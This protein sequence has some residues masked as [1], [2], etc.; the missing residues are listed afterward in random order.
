M[1]ATV[2][3]QAEE[4]PWTWEQCAQGWEADP[5]GGE[6]DYWLEP[7]HI[8]GELPEGL[9]GTLLRNGPGSIRVHGQA[10]EHPIDGDG[11]VAGLTFTGDGR[12]HYRARFV[13]SKHRRVETEAQQMRYRGQMGSLPPHFSRLKA[14]VN[15]IGT[16]AFGRRKNPFPF[17]NPSNTNVFYWAGKLLA[18]Y[19]THMPHSLHPTTFETLGVERFDGA[20]KRVKTFAAHFRVDPKTGHL[21]TLSA[22]PK[23]GKRPAVLLFSEFDQDWNPI[24]Q[25]EHHIEGLNYVHDFAM[26]PNYLIVQMT[27]FVQVDALVGLKI[28]SGFS[29]PGELMRHY[30]EL[31]SKIIVIPRYKGAGWVEDQA[32]LNPIHFDDVSPVHVYHFGTATETDEGLELTAVCLSPPFN[33]H[34]DQKVWLSNT[35]SAPGFFCR[36][37]LKWPSNDGEPGRLSRNQID[38]CSCEFPIVDTRYHGQRQRYVYLMANDRPGQNLPYRDI[39]KCDVVQG[40]EGRQVWHSEGL[41]G[42]PTFA[43]G[44]AR[45]TDGDD[46]WL[47]VQLYRPEHN[48]TQFVI[49]DAKNVDAGPVCRLHL[50]H[51]VPFSFHTTFCPEPI[52]IEHSPSQG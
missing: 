38:D 37:A 29:S 42:E 11:L 16:V 35:N 6:H 18:A 21:V 10:L 44:T 47:I 30:P 26:T 23:V 45:S 1:S 22:R 52:G 28:L 43:P 33:M 7:K 12:V 34:W 17:R 9:M 19:E 41:V 5:A 24:R 48:T 25:Q 15:A 49:L 2:H 39:V 20:L 36:Y 46:G 13:Q 31:P 40:G 4:M 14:T 8:E 32:E 3:N 51:H 27:P 50:P